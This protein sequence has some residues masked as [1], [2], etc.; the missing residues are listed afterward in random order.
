MQIIFPGNFTTSYSFC[1][2][3]GYKLSVTAETLPIKFDAGSN[4]FL[5]ETIDISLGD[6]TILVTID[7]YLVDYRT[8]TG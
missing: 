5:V 3:I 2:E 4:S 6:S 8:I 1:G 7:P